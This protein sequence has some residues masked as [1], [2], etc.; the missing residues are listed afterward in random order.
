VATR[1]YVRRQGEPW[2]TGNVCPAA[3]AWTCPLG[4]TYSK[5]VMLRYHFFDIDIRY[6]IAGKSVAQWLASRLMAREIKGSTLIAAA[7][8]LPCEA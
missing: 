1:R 4:R 2:H 8:Q 6:F 3:P 5:V 7:F